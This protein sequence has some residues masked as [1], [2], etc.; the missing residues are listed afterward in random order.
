MPREALHMVPAA[1]KPCSKVS[2]ARRSHCVTPS[3]VHS[4]AETRPCSE[5][6]P[7][8][9]PPSTTGRKV[10][11]V[12]VSMACAC[13]LTFSRCAN[14]LALVQHALL[15]LVHAD[16]HSWLAAPPWLHISARCMPVARKSRSRA[17]V[18]PRGSGRICTCIAST[19][20]MPGAQVRGEQAITSATGVV[21]S[22]G[23]LACMATSSR[24]QTASSHLSH[25][26][27]LDRLSWTV[28]HPQCAPLRVSAAA[29]STAAQVP[30]CT[31]TDVKIAAKLRVVLRHVSTEATASLWARACSDRRRSPS[32]NVPASGPPTPSAATSTHP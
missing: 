14:R 11:L 3:A 25:I 15:L 23:P 20:F 22:C 6:R 13:T 27:C 10:T 26:C 31:G 21:S 9:W 18:E 32:V 1:V 29:P 28:L 17:V 16:A 2:A 4:P 30:C 8:R 7:S 12:G 5:M 24:V 19:A